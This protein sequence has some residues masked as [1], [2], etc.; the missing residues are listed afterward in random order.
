MLLDILVV[1]LASGKCAI[2]IF[3]A[4]WKK[5]LFFCGYDLM[6]PVSQ[7]QNWISWLSDKIEK[8]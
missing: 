4:V 7:R 3:V 6:L 2:W 5:P 1:P 8:G